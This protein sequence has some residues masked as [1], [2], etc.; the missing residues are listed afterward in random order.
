MRDVVPVGFFLL[1]VA[2]ALPY[3]AAILAAALYLGWVACCFM[4]VTGGSFVGRQQGFG[5]V[6][7]P[8]QESFASLAHT[9]PTRQR[10]L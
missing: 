2:A 9:N 10:G 6:L 5:P 4:E 1:A 7:L 8:R 3:S